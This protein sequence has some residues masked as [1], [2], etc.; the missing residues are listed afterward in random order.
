MKTFYT[1][2]IL[3]SLFFYVTPILAGSPSSEISANNFAHVLGFDATKADSYVNC[4]Y[5]A[6]FQ[7]ANFTIELWAY[8]TVGGGTIL[9]TGMSPSGMGNQGYTLR[10]NNTTSKVEFTFGISTGVWQLCTSTEAI[11]LNAW[12]HI[13]II[14]NGASVQIYLNGND[15]GVTEFATAFTP[16]PQKLYIGEHPTFANRRITGQLSDIRIW[17]IARTQAEVQS[18]KGQFLTGT[19]SGLVANWHLNQTA[20]DEALDMTGVYNVARG[21]G[22]TWITNATKVDD[23]SASSMNVWPTVLK[24]GEMLNIEQVTN[25]IVRIFSAEGR[26]AKNISIGED[27]TLKQIDTS[28]L[29]PDIYVL[30][31]LSTDKHQLAKFVIK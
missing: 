26:V 1:S 27:G 30:D 9:S 20:G 28:Y 25:T 23:I 2:L 18:T 31:M 8:M 10:L 29:I 13:A 15:N 11:T 19:E 6:A 7:P 3:A 22:T 24:A 17:N 14:Y 4:N 5:N 16:S 21:A 12:H